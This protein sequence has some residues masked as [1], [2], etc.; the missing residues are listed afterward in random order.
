MK[1][2]RL[3]MLFIVIFLILVFA[4]Q[5]QMPKE[6]VWEPTF[7]H[8]DKQPFGSAVFDSLL[9]T[10][11]PRGYTIS[12]QTVG[13]LK[14]SNPKESC[15]LLIV[16]DQI[17][18][19]KNDV[20]ALLGY[21]KGGNRVMMVC[22]SFPDT[23]SRLFKFD[24]NNRSYFNVS[25][26][27]RLA[28]G[29]IHGDTVYYRGYGLYNDRE[30]H[31]CS[32]TAQSSFDCEEVHKRQEQFLSFVKANDSSDNSSDD[33]SDDSSD[34]STSSDSSN[35]S[36]TP[37]GSSKNSETSDS[38]SFSPNAFI[39]PY[40]KG[41]FVFVCCP[42]QFTNYGMLDEHNAQYVYRL[43][44][45]ISDRPVV[46]LCAYN[47]KAMSEQVSP[48]RF[49]LA[50]ASL[51]WALYLSFL[52]LLLFMF[53]AARRK[54]RSIP[55]VK[56]PDN[57]SMEFVR[58]IGTLY[59]HKKNYGDLLRKKFLYFSEEIRRSL[60]IDITGNGD[61]KR[62]AEFIARKT[63]MESDDLIKS[64]TAIRIAVQDD[65]EVDEDEM[66]KYIDKMNDILK[67]I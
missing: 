25:F 14:R 46:R 8:N 18:M 58:L 49:M 9:A 3:Y 40:G 63:G 30:F 33:S 60:H 27:K 36:D 45:T 7:S 41:T 11:M 56:E 62:M 22:T 26:L 66:K 28:K 37:S 50:H 38:L 39:H 52:T 67:H 65:Y 12:Y 5:C 32:M 15:S 47:P 10:T 59:Y 6:F 61:S 31:L 2:S 55:V 20:K 54:E 44:S 57:K 64:I 29:G 13:Q 19:S 43:L 1:G 42:L 48:L 35:S 17:E 34:S 21:V 53:F 51:R 23:I 4:L 16:A 24:V